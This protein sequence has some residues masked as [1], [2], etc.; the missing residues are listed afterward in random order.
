ML[1]GIFFSNYGKYRDK[2]PALIGN[3]PQKVFEG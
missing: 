2:I 1:S 3:S